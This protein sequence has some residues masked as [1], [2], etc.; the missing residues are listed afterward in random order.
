MAEYCLEVSLLRS[1]LLTATFAEFEC[2]SESDTYLQWMS[3][4]LQL[5]SAWN[6][7][8]SGLLTGF[9]LPESG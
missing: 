1:K 6:T 5:W 9:M 2:C 3:I 7:G 8:A 4:F